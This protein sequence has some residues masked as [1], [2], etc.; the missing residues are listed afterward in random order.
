MSRTQSDVR[1]GHRHAPSSSPLTHL[2]LVEPHVVSHD[3]KLYCS[4]PSITFDPVGVEGQRVSQLVPEWQSEAKV[5][6]L[7]K[8]VQHVEHSAAGRLVGLQE[9]DVSVG[10]T[11]AQGRTLSIR[12]REDGASSRLDAA[13]RRKDKKS[14]K[15]EGLN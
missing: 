12:G 3:V 11:G 8:A 2:G 14:F 15:H 6:F 4:G 10:V 9:H 1:T 7:S 13:T 5:P